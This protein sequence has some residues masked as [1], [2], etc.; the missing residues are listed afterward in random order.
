MIKSTFFNIAFENF[1]LGDPLPLLFVDIVRS[2]FSEHRVATLRR[3]LFSL[4]FWVCRSH[5]IQNLE[6]K[7]QTRRFSSHAAFTLR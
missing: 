4:H 7:C 6:L 2:A 5:F 1:V 3:G